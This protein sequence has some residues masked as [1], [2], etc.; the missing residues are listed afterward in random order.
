MTHIFL[1]PFRIY[2]SKKIWYK[3]L[4]GA[5]KSESQQ[6]GY[7]NCHVCDHLKEHNQVHIIRA[8]FDQ[9]VTSA[10]VSFRVPVIG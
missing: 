5:E 8:Q 10:P 6:V 1:M 7:T 9:H 3:S 2:P 4:C